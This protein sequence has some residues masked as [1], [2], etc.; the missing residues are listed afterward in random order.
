[1]DVDLEA[2]AEIVEVDSRLDGKPR[3]RQQNSSV[4]ALD[5]VEIRTEPVN[6]GTWRQAMSRAM[7]ETVSVSGGC[8]MVTGK[9]I[10]L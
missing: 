9:A 6:G 7:Q 4:A 2:H 5:I 10:Q 8:D 3:T 1:M